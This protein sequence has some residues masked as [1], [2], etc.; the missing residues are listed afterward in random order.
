MV[1]ESVINLLTAIGSISVGIGSF[2]FTIL[3]TRVRGPV[4][5]IVDIR[6]DEDWGELEK[7][8]K[9]T[10]K[11]RLRD[12][13]S[14]I[15][16]DEICSNYILASSTIINTGDRSCYFRTDYLTLTL[17][18]PKN[19]EDIAGRDPHYIFYN[20]PNYLETFCSN[21]AL[22]DFERRYV[23]TSEAEVVRNR[24][25]FPKKY[26][27]WIFAKFEIWGNFW[28]HKGKCHRIIFICR[29]NR[30]SGFVFGREKTIHR[31]DFM[32]VPEIKKEKKIKVTT[33]EV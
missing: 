1:S 20:H 5:D 19:L 18:R 10:F 14:A 15:T 32:D 9:H 2:L 17:Y 27:D 12:I 29:I 33:I 25:V 26:R 16:L 11:Y 8:V 22:D 13:C 23:T 3:R 24:L 6:I 7:E 31:M 30:K 28:D 21:I 4:I